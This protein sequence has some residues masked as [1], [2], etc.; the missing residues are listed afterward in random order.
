MALSNS[1]VLHIAQLADLALSAEE[2]T[3]LA[4]D[5]AAILAHVEQLNE[6]DTSGIAA[7]AHLAVLS[8]PLRPDVPLPSLGQAEATRAGP[9]VNAGAFAVPKFVEE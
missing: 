2:V 9:R 4:V 3:A 6:L 5:L 8:M 1:E 7:T